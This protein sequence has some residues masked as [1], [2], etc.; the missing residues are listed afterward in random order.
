MGLFKDFFS[1]DVWKSAFQVPAM[2]EPRSHE[3]DRNIDRK[4]VQRV[5]RGNVLLKLGRYSTEEDINVLREK[6][7][8]HTFR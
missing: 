3:E 2:P 6:V 7:L 5:S 1:L 4:I 8:S